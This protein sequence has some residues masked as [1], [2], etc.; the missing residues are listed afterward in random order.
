MGLGVFRAKFLYIQKV[1]LI[2]YKN[3]KA[4]NNIVI[5]LTTHFSLLVYAEKF[6]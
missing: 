3:K 5:K 4:R 6:P 1:T 2:F